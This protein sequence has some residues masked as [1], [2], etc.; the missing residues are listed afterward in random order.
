MGKLFG[1]DGIRGIANAELTCEL[2]LAV[3][4]AAAAVLTDSS[5]KRP[6][7]V[8]GSD[9]RASSDM[10]CAS[11]VAGLCSIGAD[12]IQ[13][14]VVPT[15]AVA[16]LVGKYKAD[17]GIMIS[18]SHN[19]AEFNGIKIFGG[20]GLKLPDALEECI[21]ELV[22][23]CDLWH[24]LPV[25]SEVGR[26]SAKESAAADYAEHIARSSYY[27]LGG[28]NI[29]VDCANGAASTTARLIFERL[30]ANATILCDDPDG[31]NINRSCGS[32][33]TQALAKYV[34]EHGLDLGVAFDGDADRCFCVDEHGDL[35]DGDVI[36]A[37]CALDMKRRGRLAKNTLV[38]TIMSN[39]GLAKFCEE[40][41]IRFITTTVGD[42]YVLEKIL[43]DDLSFG[44]EQSGHII[45]RDLA[46]T[47]DG[48]LTAVQLLSIVK[49]SG[50]KLSELATVMTK[51]PQI[52]VNIKASAKGKTA[53]NTDKEIAAKIEDAKKM[54]GKD[55]RIVTRPSG[56]E[57][58]IRVMVEGMDTEKIERIAADV[59][60]VIKARVGDE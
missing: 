34:T 32:T 35:I 14:G 19:P 33:H 52:T 37:I 29:A 51:Y 47:G 43:E 15:P 38:G 58:L 36:M 59:A 11:L 42:R 55:G 39:F 41:D 48:Q 3:G 7:F 24:K 9:T 8:I 6:T 49:H 17:A 31:S 1:T 22:L 40:N 25:G 50:K 4:R 30:G 10:L 13:L 5:R 60:A 46:T 45:F 53:F 44:G 28:L 26:L 2:A 20:N 57:P 21:E 56:T 16:F 54:L 18:A 27:S 23:N 12:V